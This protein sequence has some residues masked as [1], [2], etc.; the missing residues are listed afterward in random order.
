M[1]VIEVGDLSASVGHVENEGAYVGEI[2]L[3]PA[4]RTTPEAYR[5]CAQFCLEIAVELEQFQLDV[6]TNQSPNQKIAGH[7]WRCI[8][9]GAEV[10]AGSTPVHLRSS[11]DLVVASYNPE[12]AR[13]FDLHYVYVGV[14]TGLNL[15]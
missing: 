8:H 3:P 10:Y 13:Q 7:I 9:C 2:S 12:F 5:Q 1:K 6:E 4:G 14:M 11:H 15:V